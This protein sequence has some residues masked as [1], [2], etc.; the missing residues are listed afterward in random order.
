ML[1]EG[2]LLQLDSVVHEALQQGFP[3]LVGSSRGLFVCRALLWA[4]CV[5]RVPAQALF[6]LGRFIPRR[7]WMS[8]PLNK[9]P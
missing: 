2:A 6:G 7:A 9:Y 8:T 1:K 5:G 3:D 4:D